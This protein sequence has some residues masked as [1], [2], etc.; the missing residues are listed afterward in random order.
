MIYSTCPLHL[1]ASHLNYF[2]VPEINLPVLALR[3]LLYSVPLIWKTRLFCSTL[4]ANFCGR[5]RFGVVLE[6]NWLSLT[7]LFLF[8]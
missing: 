4:R 6:I 2:Q 8:A 7:Y 5:M 3:P 1:E